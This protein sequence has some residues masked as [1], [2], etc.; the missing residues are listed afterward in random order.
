MQSN[1]PLLPDYHSIRSHVLNSLNRYWS[2]N[3]HSVKF[4]PIHKNVSINCITGPLRL[5]EIKL[6]SW[7]ADCGINGYLLIPKEAITSN[8]KNAN[9]WQYVDWWLAAFLLL[10]AWHERVWEYENGALHSYSF[11]LLGW[12]ERAWEYAWVNRIGLFL[13]LWAIELADD[14][15]LFH[16]SP[17][18]IGTI[19]V[20]HD[21]DAIEKT[22][23]IR[24]K[25]SLFN[26]FNAV[27]SLVRCQFDISLKYLKHSILFF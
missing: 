24:I 6:P 17:L 11:K 13:R 23:S 1:N 4:L 14:K 7:A 8:I 9:S 3:Q 10:E 19:K 16:L 27:R 15:N 12:D 25:Q 2:N 20:T 22:F 21:V 26:I 5:V 18:P